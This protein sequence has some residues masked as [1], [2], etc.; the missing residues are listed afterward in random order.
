MCTRTSHVHT[1][2]TCAHVRYMCIRTSHVH[3]Y[4]TCAHVRHMCTR[5][6]H[7]HTYVTCTHV[8]HMCTR[9]SHV[10]TYVTCAYVRH[11]GTRTCSHFEAVIETCICVMCRVGQNHIFTRIHAVHTVN[12]AEKSP[13]IRSYT[14]DIYG[15]GQP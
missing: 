13:Y 9:T 1:Y 12:F 3:T 14:V 2:V 8:R 4:V 10:H 11:M 6:S 7:V 5:T 15:C